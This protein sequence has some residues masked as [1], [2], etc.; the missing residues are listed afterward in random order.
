MLIDSFE[1][2]F[3]R[4]YPVAGRF[5][6]AGYQIDSVFVE[7]ITP[8]APTALARYDRAGFTPDAKAEKGRR[9]AYTSDG[10]WREFRIWDMDSLEAGNVIEGPSIIEHPMTTLVVPAAN[11][12]EFDE[13]KVIWYRPR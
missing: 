3:R 5:P 6:D 13:H 10:G 4:I 8:R 11:R 12:V 7:A 9:L 1:A 2:E